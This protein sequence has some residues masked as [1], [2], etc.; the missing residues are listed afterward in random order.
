MK[1]TLGTVQTFRYRGYV[2]DE[3]TGF[4]YLQTRYYSSLWLRFVNADNV[5]IPTS[6]SMARFINLYTYCNN[7]P[8]TNN[9]AGGRW[10]IGCLFS[11]ILNVVIGTAAVITACSALAAIPV[12]STAFTIAYV[13]VAVV[14]GVAGASSVITG[15]SNAFEGITDYN[16]IRDN[17]PNEDWQNGYDFISGMSPVVATMGTY[18]L[19]P[20]MAHPPKEVRDTANYVKQ[21][22]SAPSGHSSGP[23]KGNELK[24][25]GVTAQSY[26]EYDIYANK[27]PKERGLERIVVDSNNRIYYT[28]DHYST[29]WRLMLIK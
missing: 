18:S 16:P 3:E 17:L 8:V 21:N 27:L 2:Y 9:D 29:F 19:A 13:S 14:T 6:I 22:N 24:Q 15:S 23:H 1:D 7:A 12:V 4:Y 25:L 11:G 20:F 28:N 26:M 5:I 10:S